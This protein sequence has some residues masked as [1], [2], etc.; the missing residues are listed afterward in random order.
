ML[1]WNNF[2]D[3]MAFFLLNF[4]SSQ[5]A[6]SEALK[7]FYSVVKDDFSDEEF[8][9]ISVIIA[10]QAKFFPVPNDFYSNR[11]KKPIPDCDD[12]IQNWH[13]KM[14]GRNYRLA[15]WIDAVLNFYEGERLSGNSFR[16]MT[17]KQWGYMQREFGRAYNA[18]CKDYEKGIC[19]RIDYNDVP[20]ITNSQNDKKTISDILKEYGIES[21]SNNQKDTKR[22]SN[23]F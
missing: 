5:S 4:P 9:Q 13:E 20:H 23:H 22:I 10:K 14:A 19:T 12:L 7:L 15:N 2:K 21:K 3:A 11:P 17:E 16:E 1:S 6:N 8:A 18:F